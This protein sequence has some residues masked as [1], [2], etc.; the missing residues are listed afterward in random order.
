[1][2]RVKFKVER[3]AW[4]E[5]AIA[6]HITEVLYP[7]VGTRAFFQDGEH[8]WQLGGNNDWFMRFDREMREVELSYRYSHTPEADAA[9]DALAV[10]LAWNMN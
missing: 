2:H 7:K 8:K 3:K 10:W 4:T 9:M 5:E 6:E 1:M